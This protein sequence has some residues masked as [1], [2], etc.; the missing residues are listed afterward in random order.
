MDISTLDLLDELYGFDLKFLDELGVLYAN[1]NG[2]WTPVALH[3]WFQAEFEI[4][5]EDE[6]NWPDSEEGK[7][8]GYETEDDIRVLEK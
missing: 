8:E 7:K 6:E 2:Y 3:C 4:L 1:S 5:A